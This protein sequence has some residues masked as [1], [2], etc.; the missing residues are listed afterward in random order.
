[1]P[2]PSI[3]GVH[4]EEVPLSAL[5]QTP[6]HIVTQGVVAEETL[7]AVIIDPKLILISTFTVSK[8]ILCLVTEVHRWRGRYSGG[9]V[10][11]RFATHL[12][13]SRTPSIVNTTHPVMGDSVDVH[14]L[15]FS[16][17]LFCMGSICKTHLRKRAVMV[18]PHLSCTLAVSNW[19]VVWVI[20]GTLCVE[21]SRT[22]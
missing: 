16:T 1:L 6:V 8:W 10:R 15:S 2:G 12:E 14:N 21:F 3:S 17:S 18:D 20:A 13:S 4:Q 11:V 7:S 5:Y 9:V 19:T 22:Y